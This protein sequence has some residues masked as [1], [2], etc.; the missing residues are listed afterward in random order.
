MCFLSAPGD[1]WNLHTKVEVVSDLHP[2]ICAPGGCI[3][4]DPSIIV[5]GQWDDGTSAGLCGVHW[6]MGGWR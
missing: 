5:R 4:T 6:S 3:Y 1:I 2:F